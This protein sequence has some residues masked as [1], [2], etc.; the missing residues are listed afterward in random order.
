VLLSLYVLWWQYTHDGQLRYMGRT[1]HQVKLNGFRIELGE[2]EKVLQMHPSVTTA[3]VVAR[4]DTPAGKALV[5]YVKLNDSTSSSTPNQS[6]GNSGSNNNS[7]YWTDQLQSILAKDLPKYMIPTF[8]V[9][10]QG[11]P[12]TPNGKIDRKQL[13]PPP[14]QV[15]R[16]VIQSCARSP[17]LG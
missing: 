7:T 17:I 6:T 1:D 3:V 16:S 11:F 5:A 8:F 4:D 14:P 15:P 12:H 13:P 10:M 2:I 9:Y